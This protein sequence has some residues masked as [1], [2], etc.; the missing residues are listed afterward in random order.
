MYQTQRESIKKYFSND[1][2]DEYLKLWNL[3]EYELYSNIIH[4]ILII[5]RDFYIIN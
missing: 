5:E 4:M 2:T 3:T 1:F